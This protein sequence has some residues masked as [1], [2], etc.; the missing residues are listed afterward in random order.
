MQY[1]VYEVARGLKYPMRAALLLALCLS[2]PAYSQPLQQAKTPEGY[3]YGWIGAM[4]KKPMPVVVFLGGQLEYNI[5]DPPQAKA[6]EILCKRVLCL[7]IDSP[8]EG[9][10]TPAS[11]ARGLVF[12]AQSLAAGKDFTGDF[13]RRANVVLDKLAKDGAV[14]RERVGVF[15]TSRGGFLGLHLAAAD[16]KIKA[17]A[18]FAPATNLAVLEEFIRTKA[19]AQKFTAAS[20][21]KFAAKLYQTPV[22]LTIGTAD[23]RVSTKAAIDFSQ[24]MLATT[25]KKGVPSMFELHVRYADGHRT[26]DGAYEEASR[27]M[28]RH[29]APANTPG[30]SHTQ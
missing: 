4:P 28:L 22:W 16:P 2:L 6:V 19:G 10:D 17:V 26:P 9:A 21:A 20:H 27:W 8:G 18:L 5:S 15:G 24:L 3:R 13:V 23:E 7:T 12:W 29:L 30:K 14:D 1:T 11:K 25:E